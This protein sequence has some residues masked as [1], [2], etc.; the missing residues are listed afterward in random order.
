MALLRHKASMFEE[1]LFQVRSGDVFERKHVR[2]LARGLEVLRAFQHGETVLGNHQIVLRT[3]LSKA[4]VSRLTYL[5]GVKA[6]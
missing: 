3:G 6:E 1:P 4:T 5:T 2:S